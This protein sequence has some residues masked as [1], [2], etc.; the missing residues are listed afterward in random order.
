MRINTA[1]LTVTGRSLEGMAIDAIA[2]TPDGSSLYALVREG[3]RIARIGVATGKVLGWAAGEG[4]DR[5]V[6]IIPW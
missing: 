1:D 3:G 5:L 6:G 4:Y 2:M